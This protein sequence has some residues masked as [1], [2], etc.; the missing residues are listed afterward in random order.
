M[1]CACLHL[2]ETWPHRNPPRIAFLLPPMGILVMCEPSFP[3]LRWRKGCWERAPTWE[4]SCMSPTLLGIFTN[5]VSKRAILF[6]SNVLC[7]FLLFML[8]KFV[9]IHSY[10][11][12]MSCLIGNKPH[13]PGALGAT[14]WV[15][16]VG[17]PQQAS[18]HKKNSMEQNKKKKIFFTDETWQKPRLIKK[19]TT[20]KLNIDN[21]Q[22]KNIH[23]IK[24]NKNAEKC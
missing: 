10:F 18:E 5:K 15:P 1:V 11:L 7:S 22:S 20:T 17:S 12:L 16:N 2:W 3:P 13:G 4:N 9:Y 21:K 14:C 24:L 19:C 8:T 23:T 6:V